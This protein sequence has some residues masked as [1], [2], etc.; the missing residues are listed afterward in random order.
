[1]RIL[2]AEDDPVARLT[3]TEHLGREHEFV[4]VADGRAA[5]K[6]FQAGPFGVVVTDWMMPF[7]DGVE[8]TRMI[9]AVRRQPYTYVILLTVLE[10]QGAF[11]E[12]M[13]AGAD[14]FLAKPVD[15]EAL[16]ARLRVAQRIVGQLDEIE[17]LQRLLAICPSCKKI[18]DGERWI[19]LEQYTG[20]RT[21]EPFPRGICGECHEREMRAV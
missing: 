18:R 7:I 16:G 8:L 17:Q 19:P 21:D 13:A 14:D 2:I 12:G 15:F 6:A 1:M 11:S 10:G 20:Q 3:L 4:A 5:W 9:R